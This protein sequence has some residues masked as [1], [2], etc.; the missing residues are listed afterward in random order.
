MLDNL[1][2]FIKNM[3]IDYIL[4]AGPTFQ[5][6]AE[7]MQ[8]LRYPQANPIAS[9]GFT[10]EEKNE[11]AGLVVIQAIPVIYP[12]I[13]KEEWRDKG[14]G[15]ELVKMAADYIINRTK[16]PR[17]LA[18]TNHP[19]IQKLITAS[20]IGMTYFDEQLFEWNREKK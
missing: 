17:V 18:H 8:H 14:V 19:G 2:D 7:Y 15:T 16:A 4:R 13:V 12:L 20:D 5:V 3:A 6:I 10:A 11:I 9:I 1:Y